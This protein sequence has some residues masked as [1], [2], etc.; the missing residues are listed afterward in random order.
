MTY[1]EQKA[2]ITKTIK[3]Q[4]VFQKVLTEKIGAAMVEQQRITGMKDLPEF[5]SEKLGNV[6]MSLTYYIAALNKRLKSSLSEVDRLIDF[7]ANL[8]QYRTQ[9]AIRSL[10]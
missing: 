10:R 4:E 7:K 8:L 9:S 5:N 2:S 3:S 6:Q 1:Q